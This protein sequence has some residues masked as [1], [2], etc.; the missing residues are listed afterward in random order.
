MPN[1][2]MPLISVEDIAK[3][4]VKVFLSDKNDRTDQRIIGPELLTYD[5]VS[6]SLLIEC[7]FLRLVPP[8]RRRLIQGSGSKDHPQ[9]RHARRAH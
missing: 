3:F 1:A 6:I 4:A 7:I 5:Q 8:G 2:K 9:G